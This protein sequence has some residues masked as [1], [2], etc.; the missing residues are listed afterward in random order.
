MRRYVAS[1][2]CY[3]CSLSVISLQGARIREKVSVQPQIHAFDLD[4][5]INAR[6]RYSIV[7]GMYLYLCCLILKTVVLTLCV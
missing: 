2:P 5:G 6:L 7:L 3:A 1:F 4:T